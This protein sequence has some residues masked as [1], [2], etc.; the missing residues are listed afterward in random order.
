[1]LKVFFPFSFF[2]LLLL[3]PVSF[4]SEQEQLPPG[5]LTVQKYTEFLQATA[6]TDTYTLFNEKMQDDLLIRCI[7][8]EGEPGAYTYEA[9]PERANDPVPYVSHLSAERYCNWLQNGKREGEQ[10]ETTT[11]RG[12][13]KLDGTMEEDPKPEEAATYFL[14]A[15]TNNQID[16]SLASNLTTYIIITHLG[17]SFRFSNTSP[18]DETAAWTIGGVIVGVA[19][20]AAVLHYRGGMC[21]EEPSDDHYVDSEQETQQERRREETEEMYAEQR[22]S[23]N[24]SELN[25]EDNSSTTR[26]AAPQEPWATSTKWTINKDYLKWIVAQRDSKLSLIAQLASLSEDQRQEIYEPNS[27]VDQF[28]P[29]II[30]NYEQVDKY[31][32]LMGAKLSSPNS[33]MGPYNKNSQ[34]EA[35]LRNCKQDL[36]DQYKN[37]NNSRTPEEFQTTFFSR[38]LDP[39]YCRAKAYQDFIKKLTTEYEIGQQYWPYERLLKEWQNQAATA[40]WA[41]PLEQETELRALIATIPAWKRPTKKIPVLRQ[42][43]S[44]SFKETVDIHGDA[45]ESAAL[46]DKLSRLIPTERLHPDDKRTDS[47]GCKTKQRLLTLSVQWCT[48]N[49]G[50]SFYDTICQKLSSPKTSI[51]WNSQEEWHLWN[52]QFKKSPSFVQE[53]IKRKTDLLDDWENWREKFHTSLL[54][55][56]AELQRAAAIWKDQVEA[57]H[58]ELTKLSETVQNI[59]DGEHTITSTLPIK[60]DFTTLFRTTFAH[61]HRISTH[62]E[63][64]PSNILEP[65]FEQEAH[66]K[67][68]L[69][70]WHDCL[71]Q[72]LGRLNFFPFHFQMQVKTVITATQTL[73][74]LVDQYEDQALRLRQ[75]AREEKAQQQSTAAALIESAP[76]VTPESQ[77]NS[78]DDTDSDETDHEITPVHR[79]RAKMLPSSSPSTKPATHFSFPAVTGNSL[80]VLP[81]ATMD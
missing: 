21:G 35:W 63:A 80:E 53:A 4:G 44:I 50:N 14:P 25:Q 55:N 13:Y 72:N 43:R 30:E 56:E 3:P 40:P 76:P 75:I 67:T 34:I 10:D 51:T 37:F 16:S 33:D 69:T 48:K 46:S 79:S 29:T 70:T 2:L 74:T 26:S 1:M 81:P 9:I 78:I 45:V 6:A 62:I 31:F 59:L 28:I 52:Q 61:L 36:Y 17:D 7:L 15:S 71:E 73:A 19:G 23:H 49:P 32:Y 11:E 8:R 64:A 65:L 24:S 12:A 47:W 5:T 41:L 60:R 18:Q 58:T 54:S 39:E 68:F 20:L 42:P 66:I 77:R 27:R 22:E 38:F 57:I